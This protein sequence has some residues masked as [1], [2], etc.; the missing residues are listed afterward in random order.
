MKHPGMR[1]D[2]P[3]A[4]EM[5]NVSSRDQP[6]LALSRPGEVN[7]EG[8]KQGTLYK[9]GSCHLVISPNISGTYKGGIR[10]PI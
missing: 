5:P 7:G 2:G 6:P 8:N 10:K 4:A 1:V 9:V 3:A